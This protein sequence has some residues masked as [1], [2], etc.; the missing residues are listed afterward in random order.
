MYSVSMA[1]YFMKYITGDGFQNVLNKNKRVYLCGNLKQGT[2]N[3]YIP[4]DAYEIGISQYDEFTVEKAH[5]HRFNTEYNYVMEGT[6]KVFVFRENKEYTFE[7]GSLFVIEP[8][9]PYKTKAVKGTKVI[10]SKV[11]GG[12]DKELTPQLEKDMKS[13][14]KSWEMKK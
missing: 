3:K 2:E 9:M 4:T 6:V 14:G 13:W 7:A 11:P 1:G 5:L 10:F 8:D 12:N